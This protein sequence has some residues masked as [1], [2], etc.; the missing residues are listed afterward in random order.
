MQCLEC[1]AD[2]TV[3]GNPNPRLHSPKLRRQ[4]RI[5]EE[6]CGNRPGPR[7]DN[8]LGVRHRRLLPDPDGM[9]E[10]DLVRPHAATDL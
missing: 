4:A 1:R 5:R 2:S 8:S 10:Q 9:L 6:L 3:A 7:A